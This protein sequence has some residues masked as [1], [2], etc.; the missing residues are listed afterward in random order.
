MFVADM[1]CALIL[2]LCDLVYP[3]IT[4]SML[5]VYI[6]NNQIRL[7]VLWAVILLV[8]YIV[9]LGMNSLSPIGVISSASICRRTCGA[10]CSITSNGSR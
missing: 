2:A 3:T 10:T 8:I 9:K 6:P 5:N 1:I 7:L 4:R